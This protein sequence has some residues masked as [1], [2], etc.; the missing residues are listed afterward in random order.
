MPYLN[1]LRPSGTAAVSASTYNSYRQAVCLVF[2]YLMKPAALEKNPVEEVKKKTAEIQSRK[3]F[4]QK[5]VE[6]IF[7]GFDQGFFYETEIEQMG[8]GRKRIKKTVTLEYKPKFKDQMRVLLNLCCWT[9]CRGQ[10]AC[11]MQWG[12]VDLQRNV[13]SFAP[14]KDGPEDWR[15]GCHDPDSSEPIRRPDRCST[16]GKSK[17]SRGWIIFFRMSRTVTGATLPESKRTL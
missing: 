8:T 10:D 14:I 2:H 9:G 11:L 15:P 12:S 5:Q 1:I 3:E 16:N 13:I 6:A 17:T 4:T 7:S